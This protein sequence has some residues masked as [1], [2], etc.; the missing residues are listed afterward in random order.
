MKLLKN[1]TITGGIVSIDLIP[2]SNKTSRPG[3]IM[4]PT[5]ITIHNTGNGV[6]GAD[7][8]MHTQYVDNTTGYVSWHFTVDEDKIFQEIPIYENAW[9]AGDS[10]KGKGNRNSIGI[11]I[12]EN[13]DGDYDKAEMNT[14]ELVAF[15]MQELNIPIDNVVPHQHWNG[16]YCPHIILDYGWDKFIKKVEDFIGGESV[17][18]NEV[19]KLLE[20][21]AVENKYDSIDRTG[22]L[23]IIYETTTGK[24]VESLVEEARV[25]EEKRKQEEADKV[26]EV[27]VDTSNYPVL[28]HKATGEYV[29]ILENRL[30]EL[31]YMSRFVDS[32]FG[33]STVDAVK[34]FQSD[35]GLAVDGSVGRNTWKELYAD[36][37]T[38]D[39]DGM[40]Y[41]LI[42]YK[43]HT[44]LHIFRS[45]TPP[46]LVLGKVNKLETLTTIANQYDNVICAV[47]GQMYAFN[48]TENDGYGEIITDN[49]S[50]KDVKDFY[51]GGN[52][53]FI[54]YIVNKD[55]TVKIEQVQDIKDINRL[56]G[57][58]VNSE[59]VMGTSYAIMVDGKPSTLNQNIFTH[60]TGYHNRTM[61][62]FDSV[63]KIHCVIVADGRTK[64]NKGLRAADQ[65]E[66][67]KMLKITDM[68][69]LD[70]GGSSVMLV[71]GRVVTENNP[72]RAI[73]SALIFQ[74]K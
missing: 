20:K 4:N 55:G 35:R 30:K 23:K 64:L 43:D 52:P 47:N 51:Q 50:G 40:G 74:S 1:G 29:K 26:V 73:G 68:C 71:N 15:L 12:C 7:A 65:L 21:W 67:A 57:F 16:K 70:G 9:H 8:E 41:E 28:K 37:S 18:S 5:Y 72:T 6:K 42:R 3:Y 27:T 59:F 32:Y 38:K 58:Q 69:N 17:I 54:T 60:S 14:I 22:L 63:N 66:V 48:G 13:I 31:G 49:G 36:V 61:I 53:T 34:R 10:S 33:T 11:E 39:K 44:N 56:I 45:K 19:T 24:K 46:N 25:E 2:A 62:A